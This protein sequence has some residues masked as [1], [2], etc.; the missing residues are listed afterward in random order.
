MTVGGVSL[1]PGRPLPGGLAGLRRAGGK[2]RAGWQAW[3][4]LGH[5]SGM[6]KFGGARTTPCGAGA[7]G[8]NGLQTLGNDCTV[9]KKSLRGSPDAGPWLLPTL[10]AAFRVTLG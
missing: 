3:G 10:C 2:G 4:S 5:S 7:Q 1:G 9:E 8:Q 6:A